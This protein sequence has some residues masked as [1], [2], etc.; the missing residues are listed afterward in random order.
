MVPPPVNASKN[1]GAAHVLGTAQRR[2]F[3]GAQIAPVSP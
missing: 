1:G 3:T 2:V